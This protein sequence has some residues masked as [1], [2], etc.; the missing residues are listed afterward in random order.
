MLSA[1]YEF[2]ALDEEGQ[3][4]SDCRG[5]GQFE[6]KVCRAHV[7]HRSRECNDTVSVT[8]RYGPWPLLENEDEAYDVI[9]WGAGAH[10]VPPDI[11]YSTRYGVF[12][13]DAVWERVIQPTC[14]MRP[15]LWLPVKKSWRPQVFWLATHA[16]LKVRF[17]DEQ[18]DHIQEYNTGMSNLLRNRCGIPSLDVFGMTSKLV[19]S[20][21]DDA[22]NMTWDGAHW[23]R[24]VNLLKAQLALYAIFNITA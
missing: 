4:R 13:S 20:L 18:N 14:V 2:G 5:D 12:S 11:D 1:N 9:F 16:R 17:P 10:P 3:L 8:L 7:R 23:S 19:T 22:R 15:F 6:E 24:S 21:P